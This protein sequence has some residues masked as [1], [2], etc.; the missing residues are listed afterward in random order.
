LNFSTYNKKQ[1]D[2]PG[3]FAEV[4][5]NLPKKEGSRYFKET[6]LWSNDLLLWQ[7]GVA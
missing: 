6:F 2:S 7:V 1:G 4:P 3:K 5:G